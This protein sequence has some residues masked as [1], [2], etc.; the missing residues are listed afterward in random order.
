MKLQDAIQASEHGMAVAR[1]ATADKPPFYV[2]AGPVYAETVERND[3]TTVKYDACVYSLQWKGRTFDAV[4]FWPVE[5]VARMAAPDS[6]QPV[7]D[8]TCI[9]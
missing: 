1:M 2:W 8:D 3:G 4:K 5:D 9:F 7:D 6:W